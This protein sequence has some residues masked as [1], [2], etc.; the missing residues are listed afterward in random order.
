M[1][2]KRISDWDTIPTWL[3]FL[4]A[5][6]SIAALCTAAYFLAVALAVTA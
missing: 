2:W 3:L 1:T 4:V 6:F 5:I